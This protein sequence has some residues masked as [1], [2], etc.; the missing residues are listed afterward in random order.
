LF[1][2]SHFDDETHPKPSMLSWSHSM[3]SSVSGLASQ[4]SKQIW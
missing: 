2:V 4:E 3:L 1:A